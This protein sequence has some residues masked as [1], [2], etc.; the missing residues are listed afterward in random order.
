MH[1]GLQFAMIELF[2]HRPLN[3]DA[4][5]P[6]VG[7]EGPDRAQELGE[8]HIGRKGALLEGQARPLGRA[9]LV[10]HIELDFGHFADGDG[11]QLHRP[12]AFS[13]FGRR[14]SNIG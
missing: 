5:Y 13:Q 2:R 10:P 1:R 9:A 3:D 12:A 6:R 4:G 8:G 11:N 14:N 7:V